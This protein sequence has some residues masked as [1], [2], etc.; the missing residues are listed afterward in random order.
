MRSTRRLAIAGAALVLGSVLAACGGTTAHVGG[1]SAAKGKPIKGGTVTVAQLSGA[2]P[3]D[4]FPLQPATNAN[5]YNEDFVLGAWP[6]LVTVGD[7]TKSVVNTK[8]SLFSSMTWSQNDSAVTI[9]LKPWNWS[10]GQPITA[11]DFTFVYNLLK[12]NYNDWLEYFPGLFPADVTKITTLNTHTIEMTLNHSYNPAFYEDDVLSYLPLLPQHVMDRTSLTGKVGNFDETAAGSKAVWSFL[13]KQGQ[14]ESTF[15]TSP[16]WKVVDGPWKISSFQTDGFYS[17]TPNTAY[18][19]PAKPL[20]SKVNFTPF[21]TDAAEMDTLRSGSSLTIGYLP[22]NDLKQIPALQSEGYAAAN[23]PTPGV[24]EIVPNLY[25]PVNGPILRQLY[26]RQA[27]EFLIDRPLIV[28][29]VYAGYADP[30]NGAVP[31]QLRPAV[32][33]AAGEVGRPVPV[34]AVEGHRAAEGARLEGRA[35]RRGHL[36]V[37]GHRA[38]RLRRRDQRGREAE[39]PADL[40]LRLGHV[41]R[42]ERRH[43]EHRGAGRRS[44]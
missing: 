21:T 36:P 13:Q 32:G 3:N 4:I 8:E 23:V 42:A 40:L 38:K 39:L 15:T 30:G 24:A 6:N 41:R 43:P 28:S 34:L 22:L 16:L 10:D 2:S 7:G 11:R 27:F 29:K 14:Q 18:S 17:W 20:L 5:G 35:E 26:L 19:G 12:A 31:V 9:V 37:R 33:L 25:N 44:R 1:G